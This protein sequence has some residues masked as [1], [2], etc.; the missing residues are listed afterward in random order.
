MKRRDAT[1]ADTA[2]E[3]FVHFDAGEPG[4]G[5]ELAAWIDERPD[6]ERAL[7]RVELA[8]EL[9]RRLGSDPHS[10]LYAE[11]ANAARSTPRRRFVT[12]WLTKGGALAAALGVAV[13]V[14]RGPASS[15]APAPVEINAARLVA[16]D[17]PSNPVAVLPTGVVVDASAVAVL[18]F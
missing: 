3:R 17:A 10:A 13:L 4:A 7:E 5:A 2:A 11:A 16:F 1:H 12:P 9:G 6:N 14:T 18:P 15:T 8:A